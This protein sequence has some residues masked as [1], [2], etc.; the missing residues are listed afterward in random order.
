[1]LLPETCGNDWN[2][3]KRKKPTKQPTKTLFSLKI[4]CGGRI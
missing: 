2:K 3:D 4:G 1:M